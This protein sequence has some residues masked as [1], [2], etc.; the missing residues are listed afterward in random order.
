[1]KYFGK[2]SKNW[3]ALVLVVAIT[4]CSVMISL[5][6][7]ADENETV[8][9]VLDAATN[10]GTVDGGATKIIEATAKEE[11][12]PSVEVG[13]PAADQ[14]FIGWSTDKDAFVGEL[15]FTPKNDTTYYAIYGYVFYV[16]GSVTDASAALGT[17]ENPCT[18]ISATTIPS[19]AIQATAAT[20][21]VAVLNG[22][23]TITITS[24]TNFTAVDKRLYITGKDPT[25][26][27]DNEIKAK[28]EQFA[29]GTGANAYAQF[30]KGIYLDYLT[31]ESGNGIIYSRS[32]LDFRLG[33]NFDGAG[34]VYITGLE[35]ATVPS[36]YM[37]IAASNI[38][39]I[40][41][42][43]RNSSGTVTGDATIVLNGGYINHHDY[44]VT[45]PAK[46]GGNLNAIVND[47]D[48]NVL[49]FNTD[50]VTSVGGAI[51]YVFNNGTLAKIKGKTNASLKFNWNYANSQG[52][53]DS[54]IDTAGGFY[55]IDSA[56]GGKVTPTSIPGKFMVEFDEDYNTVSVN[57]QEV[58]LDKNNCFMVTGST[59]AITNPTDSDWIKV[60]YSYKQNE[61]TESETF[62]LD[63]GTNGGN[64]SGAATKE[65]AITAS[66]AYTPNVTVTAPEGLQFIGWSKDKDNYV[67]ELTITPQKGETYY[68]IF[69]EVIYVGGSATD[70]TADKGTKANPLT[71]FSY[72]AS[73]TFPFKTTAKNCVAVLNGSATIAS[74][75]SWTTQ[76]DKRV[77]ITGLDPTTGVKNTTSIAINTFALGQSG[78]VVFGQ[79]VYM[80][81]FTVTSAK[82]ETFALYLRS[83]AQKFVFGPNIVN[84]GVLLIGSIEGKIPSMY[85]EL[86]TNHFGANSSYFGMVALNADQATIN[87]TQVEGDATLVINNGL[88]ANYN[89]GVYLGGTVGGNL[90]VVVNDYQTGD[91]ACLRVNTSK[92]VS[93]GSINYIFNNN[94]RTKPLAR[95]FMLNVSSGTAADSSISTKTQGGFYY[96][97]SAIGGKVMPTETAGKF[98]VTFDEGYNAVTINGMPVALDSNNCFTINPVDRAV[99]YA[100]ANYNNS[101]DEGWTKV[102]YYYEQKEEAPTGDLAF[103]LDAGT[104]GGTVSGSS[105][106]E[107]YVNS[108]DTYTSNVIVG[109]PTGLQFIGWSK[110]KD[111]YVGELT[112]TPQN[113]TTYYAI[114]GE[115]IYV[116]G[117]IGK[118]PANGGLGT[119][120]KPYL[121]FST[122]TI[123]S[124]PFSKTSYKNCVA[125]LSGPV[126]L[127]SISQW[128]VQANRRLYITGLDP[129]TGI[130]NETA[131]TVDTFALGGGATAVF[132]AGF[133][134][135][136]CKIVKVNNPTNPAFYMR[137]AAKNFKI[138]NNVEYTGSE[139]LMISGITHS[140]P[141]VYIESG[142]SMAEQIKVLESTTYKVTG[143]ATVVINGGKLVS[144]Q[145]GVK[146]LGTVEGNLSVVVN[147]YADNAVLRVATDYLQSAGSI[148]YIF[149][150]NART[151][152]N[153]TLMNLNTNINTGICS[154]VPTQGGF[155]YIDGGK[156]GKVMPTATAGKFKVEFDE[157]YNYIKVN[158]KKVTLDSDNCFTLTASAAS[159][160]TPAESDWQKIT[161][162]YEGDVSNENIFT[163]PVNH[164]LDLSTVGVNFDN[165]GLVSGADI[166]WDAY[167]GSDAIISN[168][169]LVVFAESE[170]T[171]NAT[172]GGEVACVTFEFAYGAE[173]DLQVTRFAGDKMVVTPVQEENNAYTVTIEENENLALKYGTLTLTVD[174]SVEKIVQASDVTG[175]AF[176]FTV[177]APEKMQLSADFTTLSTRGV[178]VYPLG[179]QVR[180]AT[181]EL[182]AGLRFVTR[183]PQIT[184]NG[185]GGTLDSKY[186]QVGVLIIPK[187]LWT[188]DTLPTAAEL[189]E[190]PNDKEKNTKVSMGAANASNVFV[191]TLMTSTE[192]YSDVAALLVD[193]PENMK[194]IE[195]VAIPYLIDTQDNV[196]F[197]DG[198]LDSN[199]QFTSASKA[200]YSFV[201]SYNAMIK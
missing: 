120:D 104:N 77:Y 149:N 10:G 49:S 90:S 147:G 26:G 186:S 58:E 1:M 57:G 168:G 24:L 181:Q 162:H 138:G 56:V 180:A 106:K 150:N 20:N 2:A 14:K 101:G 173:T 170:I 65:E 54:L 100:N 40:Q 111:A 195:I 165:A 17:K 153:W 59:S 6:V 163:V 115:V 38:S 158:G 102:G 66:G 105:T 72:A 126:T 22:T 174:G 30:K 122:S 69:G 64:I 190:D 197:A 33:K 189:K 193:I 12:T 53:Q 178:S 8:S 3:L 136:N 13:T 123:S 46:V 118:T 154:T 185:Q 99:L 184:G 128:T 39:N 124:L 44:G 103:T 177:A 11:Y 113:G 112:F 132:D 192:A 199:G 188:R 127:N 68:A 143:D 37:D 159:V 71:G 84:N 73:N 152:I 201:M 51:N 121:G 35:T 142:I 116:D 183:F 169:K 74:I 70:S 144:Q 171:L 41:M 27:V 110:D 119:K 131:V 25:T 155:Y 108:G 92:L 96:I 187:V 88:F 87:K 148:N 134:I 176:K 129:T 198:L 179:V 141:S 7:L 146:F 133:Y 76:A 194:D 29:F 83:G 36:L 93:A 125:V 16:G 28:I 5:A 95:A 78:K 34:T 82:N 4:L 97:D 47:Y 86:G 89:G 21:C 109:A 151:G 135:D 15:T 42:Q 45:F 91:A 80:D 85:V 175:K 98:K 117:D 31:Y 182:S 156:G 164:V 55:Y 81:H 114:F 61:P 67:G 196:T 23:Q 145:G 62:T 9:F 139:K 107:M 19:A 43:N 137:G 18:S 160:V 172:Y 60:T 75:S 161:Y 157:G 50:K 52:S 79:G 167:S 191:K 63:A 140:I 94:S 166:V 130:Q 48:G 200:N 32:V